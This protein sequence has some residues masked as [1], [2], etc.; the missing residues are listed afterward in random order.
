MFCGQS[1][2]DAVVLVTI[3]KDNTRIKCF[4]EVLQVQ[5]DF[6]IL[7]YKKVFSQKV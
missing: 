2:A 5:T 4:I 6:Y 1:E 3:L 7:C